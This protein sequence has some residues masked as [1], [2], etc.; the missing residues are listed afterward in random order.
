MKN[1]VD[2][3][4]GDPSMKRKRVETEV[5][6]NAH[7]FPVTEP[8]PA[9]FPNAEFFHTPRET[10]PS[11]HEAELYE[12]LEEHLHHPFPHQSIVSSFSALISPY[13]KNF[14]SPQLSDFV[15]STPPPP[16]NT[17]TSTA[18]LFT[19]LPKHPFSST[20]GG[21][22]FDNIFTN[23]PTAPS[24]QHVP[25]PSFHPFTRCSAFTNFHPSRPSFVG[26]KWI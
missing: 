8:I 18:S 24:P 22:F 14:T 7:P 11:F 25:L 17:T 9:P 1:P 5:P 23:P 13:S 2:I 16:Y 10:T 4:Y 26:T 12:N 20:I 21:S 19:S 3:D 15:S 6:Q